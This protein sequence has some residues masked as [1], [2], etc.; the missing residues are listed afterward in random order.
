[1]LTNSTHGVSLLTTNS[2][3]AI[4]PGNVYFLG[5]QNTNSAAVGYALQVNFLLATPPNPVPISGILATNI[6]G[7]NSFVLTWLA[8]VN[9]SFQ[10]RWA[11][12]LI[13]PIAWTTFPGV[14]SS[15][16]GSFIFMDPTSPLVMKFYQLM[17]VP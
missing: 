4:V 16:N 11:T 8:P 17:I 12:N 13:P 6:G 5:V 14:I 9:D 2:T 10:V 3:P 1:L 7:T 15:T